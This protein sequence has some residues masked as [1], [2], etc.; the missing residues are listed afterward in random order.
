[1]ADSTPSDFRQGGAQEYYKPPPKRIVICCDGTWQ[2]SVTNV[3]NVPSNVTR[4]ARYLTKT[5]KDE[6]GQE[7]Q[8]LVYYDAG[9]GTGVSGVEAALQGGTGSGFVG[10]VIEAYNF[11]TLNYN[12][13][14]KIFCFGFSRGAYTARAVAGLVTDIGIIGRRDMQDFPELYRLYQ[15]HTDSHT[16]R[17][18]KAWREWCSGKLAP[19]SKRKDLPYGWFKSPFAWERRPHVAAPEST[20][21]IEAIGVFDTVGSL[22]IPDIEGVTGYLVTWAGKKVPVEHFGFHNV[23]LSPCKCTQV[24][25]NP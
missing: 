13:G 5:D 2:S 8:Q 7:W 21:W 9:I 18:S 19:E 22:G 14:D 16:F 12:A 25:W 6:H 20:R 11:I 1:M 4:I 24:M 3:T 15:D 10:N 23:A 17:K